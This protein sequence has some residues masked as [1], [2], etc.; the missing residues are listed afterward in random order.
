[1]T[2]SKTNV[3]YGIARKIISLPKDDYK[4]AIYRVMEEEDQLKMSHQ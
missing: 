4:G 2:L 1:M 3:Y